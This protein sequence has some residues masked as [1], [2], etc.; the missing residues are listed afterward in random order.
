M[1]NALWRVRYTDPKN[2]NAGVQMLS[3]ASPDLANITAAYKRAGATAKAR[4]AK[5]GIK[6]NIQHVQCVG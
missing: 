1:T 3:L 5:R 4:L 2:P 6:A